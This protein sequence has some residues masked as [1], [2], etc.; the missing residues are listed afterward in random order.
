MIKV[1][2]VMIRVVLI[3]A[4]PNSQSSKIESTV[5]ALCIRIKERLVTE[6]VMAPVAQILMALL[7]LGSARNNLEFVFLG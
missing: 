7:T 1:M 5:R 4:I 3:I 6:P 2:A